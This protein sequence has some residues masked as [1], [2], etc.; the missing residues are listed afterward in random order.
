MLFIL[1]GPPRAGKNTIG[2]LLAKQFDRGVLIDVDKVRWMVIKGHMAPWE[3][4]EGKKQQ[5]L[6]VVNTCILTK[7][8][9]DSGFNVVIADVIDSQTAIIYKDKLKE[10]RPK[11][12]LLLPAF[13]EIIRRKKY[14]PSFI[15]EQEIEMLYKG[16]EKFKEYDEKIDNTNLT[17]NQVVEKLFNLK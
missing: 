7:N 9:I 14:R 13:E 6:G 5:I 12:I 2:E 15:I 3:G 17:P 8:Y 16:Q 10:Y 11:I 1:T 4:S